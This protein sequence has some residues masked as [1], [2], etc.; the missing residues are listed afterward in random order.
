M[1]DFSFGGL[2]GRA[3]LVVAALAVSACAGRGGSVPYEPTGF[4]APDTQ[5][6]PVANASHPIGAL[7]TITVSVFQ[8]ESLSGDYKVDAQGKIDYPLLG[9]IQ[10]QGRTTQELRDQVATA[11]SQK[12]LQSPN[13][14]IAIKDRAEQTI[15]VDGSVR[16][17]GL[18]TVKGPTTLLQAVAMAKGT[19]EDA[20]PS[21]VV[22]FRTI[23]GEKMAGAF[24]LQDIRR[25][26]AEDPIIYGNDIVI[27]DGS[28]ARAV[29]RDLMST[30]PLLTILRPF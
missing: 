9:S 8:V 23:R 27:V 28:R 29:Y 10:A 14:Q 26:K 22:V 20:N 3:L 17:P 6:Q 4:Q 5:G 24:D 18:F 25:A 1:R 11:L 12:Y 16:S 7:D 15:T 30:L 21:R 2:I 13:V 19:S